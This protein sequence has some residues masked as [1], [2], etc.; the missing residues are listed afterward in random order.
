[1]YNLQENG[2]QL[3]IFVQDIQSYTCNNVSASFDHL[4]E[5]IVLKAKIILI[6]SP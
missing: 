2:I 6:M 4:D 3:E 1:M 5:F